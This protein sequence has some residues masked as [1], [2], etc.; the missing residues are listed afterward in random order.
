MTG[1]FIRLTE[2]QRC[3]HLNDAAYNR[4]QR[5]L[6]DNM[7]IGWK[8]IFGGINV[9]SSFTLLTK[10]WDPNAYSPT[11][12]KIKEALESEMPSRDQRQNL[13]Y[14]AE[15]REWRKTLDA[16]WLTFK[17]HT[18]NPQKTSILIST[19]SRVWKKLTFE[20]FQV[21][22]QTLFPNT[23]NIDLYSLPRICFLFFFFTIFLLIIMDE[24]MINQT[25]E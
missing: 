18:F 20:T 10:W 19:L 23:L 5:K 22:K 14:E 1:K 21:K 24:S 2:W 17:S 8:S 13:T 15:N 12:T 9:F 7:R 3:S 25:F 16:K 6:N 11:M 4:G